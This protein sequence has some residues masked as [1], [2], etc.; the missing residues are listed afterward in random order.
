MGNEAG[1]Q[2]GRLS[3]CEEKKVGGV[4]VEGWDRYNILFNRRLTAR[5]YERTFDYVRDESR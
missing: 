5:K 2:P 3:W 1:P 4:M